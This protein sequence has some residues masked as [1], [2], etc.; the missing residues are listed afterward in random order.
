MKFETLSEFLARIGSRVHAVVGN[1]SLAF[2]PDSQRFNA[3]L[4]D[5]YLVSGSYS[6]QQIGFVLRPVAE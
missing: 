6:A 4:L 3:Y 5:D 2:V 1:E